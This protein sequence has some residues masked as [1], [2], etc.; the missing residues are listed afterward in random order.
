MA[1]PVDT[2]NVLIL[3]AVLLI[4]LFAAGWP[5]LAAFVGQAVT[6]IY[7]LEFVNYIQHHGLNRGMDERAN[8]SHAW[9]SRH[10]LSRWTLLEL[11][12]HPSH[13]LKSST[14]YHRLTVHDEAPQLPAGY[15]GM[16]WLAL[17]PPIFGRLMQKQHEASA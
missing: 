9:E 10:R 11:P 12:L 6:A 13:H 15:Y 16:F 8:A 4:A 7:L 5:L 1:R 2:R 14:P 3:E 17:L